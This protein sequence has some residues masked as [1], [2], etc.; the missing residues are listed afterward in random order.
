MRTFH[1]LP[2]GVEE[3]RAFVTQ[4]L[5]TLLGLAIVV[6]ASFRVLDATLRGA[7]WGAGLALLWMLV[8]AAWALEKKARRAALSHIGVDDDGLHL[9][10]ENAR[11]QKIAWSEISQAD[12]SGGKLRVTW[13]DGVLEVGAREVQDGMEMV[14][15]VLQKCGAASEAATG[16]K[17]PT[18]FI[19]LDPK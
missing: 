3:Q 8:R 2:P 18:S 9:V 6:V 10:D 15:E 16:F 4:L 7:L 14:R 19:P 1:Y 17:P 5:G 12:V 13:P 11:E